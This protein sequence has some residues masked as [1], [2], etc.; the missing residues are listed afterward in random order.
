MELR[1]PR[2]RISSGNKKNE[3][4]SIYVSVSCRSQQNNYLEEILNT[5]YI[6]Q[7]NLALDDI[8]RVSK[9]GVE[10]DFLLLV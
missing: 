6:P 5:F 10:N 9:T 4:R 8:T 7:R 3:I 1:D 2:G